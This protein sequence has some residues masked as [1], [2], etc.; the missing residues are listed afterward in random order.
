MR[1]H[2]QAVQ[3]S[4]LLHICRASVEAALLRAPSRRPKTA[5]P[6]RCCLRDL[7]LACKYHILHMHIVRLEFGKYQIPK[8][9]WFP[10]CLTNVWVTSVQL[11]SYCQ[12]LRSSKKCKASSLHVIKPAYS[13]ISAGIIFKDVFI[14]HWGL[15]HSQKPKYLKAVS[16]LHVT[17]HPLVPL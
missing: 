9:W 11:R 15:L 2:Q 12:L 10:L 17:S 4:V 5:C 13:F 1:L 7:A 14:L 3:Q 16:Y 6:P 8:L